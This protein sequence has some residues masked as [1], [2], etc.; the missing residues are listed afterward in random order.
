ME[1]CFGT[2]YKTAIDR[3]KVGGYREIVD[4]LSKGPIK[5]RKPKPEPEPTKKIEHSSSLPH[6]EIDSLILQNRQL[7]AENSMLKGFL[8]ALKGESPGIQFF[9]FDDYSV[10]SVIGE[11][12]TSSVKLVIKNSNDEFAMKELK[13]FSHKSVQR[14]IREGESMFLLRHPCILDIVAVNL[15]DANHPPS[16]ILSLE[17][18]SLET[19]I[20]KKELNNKE[21]CQIT[22]EIVLGM[23]YIHRRNFMHR[24]LKPSNILLT[25]DGHVKISD[26]G[27]AKEEDLETSQSKGVGTLRFMAPELFEENPTVPVYTNKVDVYSFAI[28]LIY[29]ITGSYPAFSLKKVVTGVLPQLPDSIVAWVRDLI[30]SCLS[31]EPA[32][33]PSFADIFETLKL[34]N[35]DIF[36]ESKGQKLSKKLENQKKEIESCIMKIEAFEYQHKDD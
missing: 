24:D 18:K 3:A 29:I 10:K 34:N 19:A 30:T 22:V 20:S 21:K 35:F 11:G 8:L 27:L 2:I 25:K 33:R 7:L 36:S 15:G 28:T 1:F 9:D 32:D 5:S 14:F 26:F 13:D 16:L 31:A 23:R 12:G 4:L 6:D 17:P